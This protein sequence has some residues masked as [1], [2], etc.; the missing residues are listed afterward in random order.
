MLKFKT[1]V[2]ALIT[3][4]AI[5]L[6]PAAQAGCGAAGRSS[7]DLPTSNLK[8]EVA[9]KEAGPKGNNGID[10]IVGLWK[11]S[12]SIKDS[13][14][15]DITVDVGIQTWHADG[16]EITNSSHSP[17]TGSFCMGV[18][19]R[20]A[21]LTYKLNHFGIPWNPSG[22]YQLGIDD[23]KLQVTLGSSGNTFTGSFSVDSEDMNGNPV[24]HV[25][26]SVSAIRITLE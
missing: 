26:G 10:S 22:Q 9:K 5:S 11:I 17:I 19:E 4:T 6:S 3:V 23:I 15:N 24:A 7:L 14:N 20:V 8:T 13:T 16:T 2:S 21:P 18:W 25:E 1:I 12:F